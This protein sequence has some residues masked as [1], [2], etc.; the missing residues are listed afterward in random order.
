MYTYIKQTKTDKQASWLADCKSNQFPA[1]VKRI[2]RIK[3][4]FRVIHNDS[5]CCWSNRPIFVGLLLAKIKW[6][7]GGVAE[8]GFDPSEWNSIKRDTLKTVTNIG[9]ATIRCKVLREKKKNSRYWCTWYWRNYVIQMNVYIYKQFT[10]FT[11]TIGQQHLYGTFTH[12]N[13]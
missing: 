9:G 11:K 12:F 2:I 5:N 7:L 8:V 6:L 3:F 1:I 4:S 10:V 13:I